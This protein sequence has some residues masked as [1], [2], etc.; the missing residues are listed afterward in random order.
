MNSSRIQT[1]ASLYANSE[2]KIK[3]RYDGIKMNKLQNDS[4]YRIY[5]KQ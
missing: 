5:T 4:I 2:M 1:Y 3:K